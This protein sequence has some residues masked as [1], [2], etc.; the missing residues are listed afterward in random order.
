MQFDN[1][2]IEELVPRETFRLIAVSESRMVFEEL[3]SRQDSGNRALGRIRI[4][5]CDVAVNVP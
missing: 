4:V 5:C 1:A 2:R 3:S